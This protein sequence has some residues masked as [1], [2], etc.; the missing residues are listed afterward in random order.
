M[1]G[2]TVQLSFCQPRCAPFHNGQSKKINNFYWS[3]SFMRD[4]CQC[5]IC[6]RT[7]S[8]ALDDSQAAVRYFLSVLFLQRHLYGLS[9]LIN[10]FAVTSVS[11][12]EF[13]YDK[14]GLLPKLIFQFF[15]AISRCVFILVSN[16][17]SWWHLAINSPFHTAHV[18][19]FF[20]HSS[21]S[22]VYQCG[23]GSFT[24]VGCAFGR[25]RPTPTNSAWQQVNSQKWRKDIREDQ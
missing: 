6:G 18:R 25:F 24:V 23:M 19:L 1:K 15:Y 13:A 7:D 4:R 16:S 9:W 5:C 11:P 20:R 21:L 2:A 17:E 3:L 8:Q 12:W 22:C 14:R 10:N